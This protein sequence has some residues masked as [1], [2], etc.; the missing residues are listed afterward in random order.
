MPISRDEAGRAR[1]AAGG[2]A[3]GLAVAVAGCDGCDPGQA[4]AG[5]PRELAPASGAGSSVAS[6]EEA[7]WREFT[8]QRAAWVEELAS[9]TLASVGR[10]D[11]KHAVFHGCYDWHSAVHG[12]WALL[13][14]HALTG[15][16]RFRQAVDASLTPDGIR[17]ELE[18]LR[19]EPGFEMPYGRAW[20]LRLALEDARVTGSDRL[21][22][23]AGEAA[24]SLRR[25]LAARA[26]G[27]S[28]AEYRNEAWALRQLYDHYAASRDDA[29][30]QWV[31]GV[32]AERFSGPAP[33]V[34]LDSDHDLRAE[35]FSRWGNWAHLLEVTHDRPAFAAWLAEQST[36]DA[37]LAPADVFHTAHHLGMNFSRAWGLWS[38]YR[39]LGDVRWRTAAV[40]HIAA[41]MGT[42]DAKKTDYGAYGHWVPQFGIYAISAT[43]E[44]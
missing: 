31:V 15:D 3:L 26:P 41:G 13:R 43:H 4:A 16:P 29:G 25:Y 14:A 24:S 11:T 44:P 36:T 32:A 35:F 23:I 33:G 19:D 40:R 7:L 18:L 2:I 30:R 38:V 9:V 1:P 17:Q 39:K 34:D 27:P 42:H 20:L 22:A 37:D 10:E 6:D 5:A 28:S 8:A 12:H 21:A